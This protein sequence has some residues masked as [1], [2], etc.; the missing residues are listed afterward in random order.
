[1]FTEDLSTFFNTAELAESAVWSVG[2]TSVSVHFFEGYESVSL[3][4]FAEI[5][6]VRYA[7]MARLDQMPTVA[8]GQA[9]TIRSVAYVIRDVQPDDTGRV[10][11]LP[12]QEP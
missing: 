2:S 7:A 12:L 3:N 8:V 5:S 1:M 10:V 6:G 4:A 11:F 9:L